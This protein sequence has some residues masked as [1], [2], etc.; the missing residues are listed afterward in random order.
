ME[1]ESPGA[2]P[3]KEDQAPS[4]ITRRN[5]L[6][7][8]GGVGVASFLGFRSSSGQSKELPVGKAIIPEVASNSTYE[9]E[10]ITSLPFSNLIQG[11]QSNFDTKMTL[12]IGDKDTFE[13]YWK[14]ATQNPI[15]EVNFS[16]KSIILAAQGPSRNGVTEVNN[17]SSNGKI[18]VEVVWSQASSDS[19]NQNS[20]S[21][22]QLIEFP[23]P[24]F[25]KEVEFR[26]ISTEG[27][28]TIET[29]ASSRTDENG[30]TVYGPQIVT[31]SEI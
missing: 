7:I 17:I 12:V 14:K 3:P 13:K 24:P 22:F 23:K 2:T 26:N 30:N 31:K 28:Y 21:S 1:N 16:E 6:G 18:T 8:L 11:I 27:N 5:F 4:K 25:G 10:T 15:P 19:P 9:Q 20:T 29:G